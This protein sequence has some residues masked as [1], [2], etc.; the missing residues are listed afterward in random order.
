MSETAWLI[1]ALIVGALTVLGWVARERAIHHRRRAHA[2]LK[3]D[4]R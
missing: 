4:K 2:A 1:L 3:G